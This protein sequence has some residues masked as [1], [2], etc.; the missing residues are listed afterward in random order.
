M[1]E[2]ILGAASMAFSLNV[3]IAVIAGITLG[4]T[5]GATPGLGSMIGIGVCLPLTFGMSPIVAISFITAIYKGSL[6]GGSISAILI[7]TPGTSAAAAT[8]FDGYPLN[9]KGQSR[10]ALQAA[11]YASF[12]GNMFSTTALVVGSIILARIAM[13]FGPPE[14][15]WVIVF[16]LIMTG[17]LAGKSVSK[18][19]LALSLGLLFGCVGLDPIISVPRFDLIADIG[20]LERIDMV[21]FLLGAFALSEI[22]IRAEES[23]ANGKTKVQNQENVNI[24]GPPIN[25][26]DI[27]ESIK[28]WLTGSIFGTIVGIIPGMGATAGAL[29]SYGASN[30]LYAGQSK[31]VKF[32]EGA[33]PGV[34][35]AESGNNAVDGSNLLPLFTLGVPGSAEAALLL[36]ALLMHGISPGPTIFQDHGVIIYGCFIAFFIA[37]FAMLVLGNLFI[38]PLTRVL[39]GDPSIVFPVVMII[40]FVGVFGLNHRMTDIGIMIV[41]GILAYFMRKV[42]I[43]IAPM[44]I[45]FVLAKQ[46]ELYF[47]QSLAMSRGNMN[48]FFNSPVSISIILICFIGMGLVVYQRYKASNTESETSSLDARKE[49]G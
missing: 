48:V 30:Q 47:R 32:G 14:M 1:L 36:A 42:S 37:N 12:A 2:S 31:G 11:L 49:V 28:A 19:M 22:F 39:K 34:V 16:A 23:R 40:C 4:I 10:K 46:I 25:F 18:G 13:K 7:N 27:K 45:A 5:L 33:I 35:A 38:K 6:Y 26:A 24:Y 8:C 29:I 44:V 20:K 41:I 21:A 15:F 9:K 43:P 17:S 3:L